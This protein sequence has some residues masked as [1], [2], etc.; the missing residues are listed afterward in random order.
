MAIISADSRDEGLPVMPNF[1]AV[2]TFI[3]MIITSPGKSPKRRFR[4]VMKMAHRCCLCKGFV[5]E[6]GGG[7][8]ES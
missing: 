3:G 5:L 6:Q 4:M 2:Y 7:Y 8:L 1:K